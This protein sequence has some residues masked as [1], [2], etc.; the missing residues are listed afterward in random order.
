MLYLTFVGL[1]FTYSK[2]VT[3]KKN[4]SSL[5]WIRDRLFLL[6]RPK[7]CLGWMKKNLRLLKKIFKKLQQ[8]EHDRYNRCLTLIFIFS[9]NTIQWQIDR[10]TDGLRDKQCLSNRVPYPLGTET[11]KTVFSPTNTYNI[12]MKPTYI[13]P[14]V[15]LHFKTC[16]L[17]LT[18]TK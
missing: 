10:R 1:K 6:N 9:Y 7:N 12:I 16:L 15:F 5:T 17:K 11:L 4:R 13:L 14:S 2:I 18:G 3:F 8:L